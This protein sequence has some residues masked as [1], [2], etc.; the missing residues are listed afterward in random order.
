MQTAESP[1]VLKSKEESGN[2]GSIFLGPCEQCRPS[3]NA[4]IDPASARV[5]KYSA[6]K[7]NKGQTSSGKI[8]PS[9]LIIPR[10]LAD[11]SKAH[12]RHPAQSLSLPS[13]LAD[14]ETKFYTR[15]KIV[16]RFL[17]FLP[18]LGLAIVLG[19]KAIP[20]LV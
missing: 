6:S 10:K 2:P 19:Y 18:T 9:L 17:V 15:K 5:L 20:A 13:S 14:S 3:L 16:F 11:A 4:S 8:N 7:R 1:E 12:G